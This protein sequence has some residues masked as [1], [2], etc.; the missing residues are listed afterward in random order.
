MGSVKRFWRL[1][2]G[3]ES[4]LY[5][6]EHE[7]QQGSWFGK[8]WS[9][10]QA[11]FWRLRN[12]NVYWRDPYGQYQ[13][14][15]ARKGCDGVEWAFGHCWAVTGIIIGLI[16]EKKKK[17]KELKFS[18]IILSIVIKECVSR[19]GGNIFCCGF[20]DLRGYFWCPN[21]YCFLFL[22]SVPFCSLKLFFFYF[23]CC[24]LRCHFRHGS[25]YLSLSAPDAPLGPKACVFLFNYENT[26][27]GR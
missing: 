5:P 17:R 22:L 1:W 21:L 24:S 15:I 27:V 12:A 26:F 6:F 2:G 3:S 16:E 14:K 4:G 7:T 25:H 19:R 18:E 8:R 9:Y 10:F 13:E 11:C 20:C 23:E